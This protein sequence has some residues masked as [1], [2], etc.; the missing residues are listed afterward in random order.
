M[1]MIEI[2]HNQ[3]RHI[4]RRNISLCLQACFNATRSFLSYRGK[5][6]SSAEI[7]QVRRRE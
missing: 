7:D 6:I 3:Y 4:D 5:N 2:L 1:D